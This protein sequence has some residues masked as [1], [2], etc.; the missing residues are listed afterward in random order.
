M[1]VIE[2]CHLCYNVIRT[3]AA[4]IEEDFPGPI[5]ENVTGRKN[6]KALSLIKPACED[7]PLRNGLVA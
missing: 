5:E 2:L 3:K 4:L 1:H 6:H 7:G